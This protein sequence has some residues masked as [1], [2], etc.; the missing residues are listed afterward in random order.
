MDLNRAKDKRVT[1]TEKIRQ[2]RMLMEQFGETLRR[3]A[4]VGALMERLGAN[5]ADSAQAM[6]DTGV[7]RACTEC[8][9][10]D[11]GSCC[12]AGIENHYTPTLLLVNLLFGAELPAGRSREGCCFFLGDRGC[13]LKVRQVLCVNYLCQAI[14]KSL[15]HQGRDRLQEAVGAELSTAFL[16]H[17]AVLRVLRATPAKDGK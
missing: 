8:D 12:G 11:G 14:Q 13:M 1:V 2:A 4:T 10:Q 15:S 3:D 5:L 7:V 9:E 16:L 6:V 17:E